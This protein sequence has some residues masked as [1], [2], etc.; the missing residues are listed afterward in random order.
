M[1]SVGM[2]PHV[3][4]TPVDTK[5]VQQMIV[6]DGIYNPKKTMLLQ[7]AE[8]NNCTIISGLE[9]FIHQA[10]EQ[11]TLWTEKEANTD[12]LRKILE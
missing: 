8:K 9:M 3:E 12:L 1:T 10:A 6:F 5:M 7:E 2:H 11:F 4:E